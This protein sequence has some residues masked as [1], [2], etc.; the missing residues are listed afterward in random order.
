MVLG[1]RV[2]LAVAVAGLVGGLVLLYGHSQRKTGILEERTTQLEAHQV[3]LKE[4]DKIKVDSAARVA[5]AEANLRETRRQTD[6]KIAEILQRDQVAKDWFNTRVPTAWV[7][8]IWMRDAGPV[9]PDRP[10]PLTIHYPPGE[11]E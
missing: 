4:F 6:A 3:W 1:Y 11:T 10:I 8:V 2:L 7:D 5:K 9:V